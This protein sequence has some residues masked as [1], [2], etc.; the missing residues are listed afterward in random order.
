LVFIGDHS[1]PSDA[2]AMPG[3]TREKSMALFDQNLSGNLGTK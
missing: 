3:E 2:N 1:D